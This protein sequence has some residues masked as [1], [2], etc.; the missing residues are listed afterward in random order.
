MS[1][2][3]ADLTPLRENPAYRRLGSGLSLGN[4]GQQLAVVAISLQVYDLTGSSFAVGLVGLFGVVPLVVLGLYGGSLVDAHDRRTV[5]LTASL[6]MWGV[7][8]ATAIQAWL[9]LRSV[10]LLYALVAVQSAAFAVNNPARQA[11]VPALVRRELL[12]A[13]NAL[14]TVSFT[15]GMAVG[16]LLGGVLVGRFGFRAAY[17]ID[18]V[19]YLAAL[20]GVFR[21]PSLP[22]QGERSRPGLRSVLEG[23]RFLGT[24]PNVRMTFLVD[25]AAMILAS[26]RALLPAVGAVVL[27]GGAVTAGALLSAA[28]LGSVLAGLF[29][30]RLGG[31]HRQGLAV[32]VCVTCWGAAIAAFGVVLALT[33]SGAAGDGKV[34]ALFWPAAACLVAA[35][36]ADAVSA[37]FRSTI[38]QVA[39]P[40]AMRGRLQGVFVVVAGGPRLGDLVAGTAADTVGIAATAIA[41]GLACVIVVLVLARLQPMFAAYDSR[42]PTP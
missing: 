15:L 14:T 42:R 10:W 18:A 3:F 8:I 37:V 22:P 6:V 32:L 25:L 4:V 24:R 12:P 16:P 26:P 20:W 1:G 7:S 30:G 39:T 5:A 23:L 40:D 35:G 36:A 38:L 9:G 27:G 13:A 34:S 33:P 19:T 21:L 31:V 41:G 11:I 17:S 28:A 2:L 29:S